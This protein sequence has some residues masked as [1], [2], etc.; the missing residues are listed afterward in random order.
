M[1]GSIQ[2]RAALNNGAEMPWLGLGVWQIDNPGELDGAVKAAVAAGYRS[3]DTADIY[4]N[5]AGVGRA[6]RECGIPREELFITTKLWSADQAKGYDAVLRAFEASRKRMGLEYLD[7][8]LIHWPIQSKFVEAWRAMVKLC[9]DGLVRAVGGSN[10]HI[11]HIEEAFDA[12]GVMP[13]VD[14]VELHP[15]LTQKPLIEFC[16]AKGVR[17]EAY[18]P[19]ANGHLRE[20]PGLDGIAAQYG[21]SPAQAVLRWN[22][23]NGV[24][25]IPKSVHRAR[26]LE[27]AAIFDFELTMQDMAA[28]DALNRDRRFFPDPDVGI[29]GNWE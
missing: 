11:H 4:G 1:A 19:L 23:Q 18:S 10:F 21:K 2:D 26:I 28:I 20:I 16:R 14:Q 3:I 27:N 15:W 29:R 17:V 24:V 8:Y 5:E 7:L 25:V 6:V 13:A 9:R 22:L 12:T